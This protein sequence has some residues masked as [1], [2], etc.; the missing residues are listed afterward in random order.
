MAATEWLERADWYSSRGMQDYAN[1]CRQKAIALE[2]RQA[3]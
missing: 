3:A 2:Q 1:E